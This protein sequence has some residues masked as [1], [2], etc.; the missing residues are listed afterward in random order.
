MRTPLVR[1]HVFFYFLP[2]YSP[3]CLFVIWWCFSTNFAGVKETLW[4]RARVLCDVCWRLV[5]RPIITIWIIS[6]RAMPTKKEPRFEP[7]MRPARRSSAFLTHRLHRQHGKI[8]AVLAFCCSFVVC[9]RACV[10]A[11]AGSYAACACSGAAPLVHCIAYESR[12]FSRRDRGAHKTPK[13]RL[14]S[15]TQPRISN[16]GPP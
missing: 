6:W 12:G 9:V 3:L 10:R 7:E 5:D 4:P 16:L 13:E 11:C 15:S 14:M 8:C 2:L 1:Q